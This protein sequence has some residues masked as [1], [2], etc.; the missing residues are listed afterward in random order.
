MKNWSEKYLE[1]GNTFQDETESSFWFKRFTTSLTI[2]NGAGAL[3]LGSY[4]SDVDSG[5]Q[6]LLSVPFGLFSVGIILSG[7]TPLFL[8]LRYSIATPPKRFKEE[9]TEGS[10]PEEGNYKHPIFWATYHFTITRLHY[11]SALISAIVFSFGL[12]F[13]YKSF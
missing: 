13:V 2:G 5:L 1:K 8:G 6:K 9:L 12:Y 10:K 7:L 3:A 11:L 4:A